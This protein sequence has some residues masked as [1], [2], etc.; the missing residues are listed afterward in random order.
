MRSAW[1]SQSMVDAD[2]LASF[3]LLRD[4]SAAQ[5]AEVA[6]RLVPRAVER[7]QILIAQSDPSKSLFF[8]LSGRFVVQPPNAMQHW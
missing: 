8:V 7:G 3:I 2:S 1:P 5:R 6:A 4:L